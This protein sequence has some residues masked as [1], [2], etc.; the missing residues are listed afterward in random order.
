MVKNIHQVFAVET[1]ILKQTVLDQ[2]WTDLHQ[3]SA[4]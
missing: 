2:Y 3:N 4:I 1:T